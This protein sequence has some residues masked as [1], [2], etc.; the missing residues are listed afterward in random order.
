VTFTTSVGEVKA[1]DAGDFYFDHSF[2]YG[3]PDRGIQV[4]SCRHG[5]IFS[6]VVARDNILAV[7]FHPEKSQAVGLRLLKSFLNR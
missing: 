3:M 5:D 2:A 7:Q 1:G 4:A 6:A